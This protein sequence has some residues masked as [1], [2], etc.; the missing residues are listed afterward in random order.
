MGKQSRLTATI[1]GLT[2]GMLEDAGGVTVVRFVLAAMVIVLPS[3]F[4]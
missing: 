3:H 2:E 1:P 4:F